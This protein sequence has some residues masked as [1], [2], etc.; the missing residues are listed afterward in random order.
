MESQITRLLKFIEE[1]RKELNQLGMCK[2]LTDPEVIDLSQ[3][4]DLLLNEYQKQHYGLRC[5]RL[6]A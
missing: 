2:P 1:T 6:G 4:L 5:Q 3:R